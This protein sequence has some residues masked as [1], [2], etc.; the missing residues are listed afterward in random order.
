MG[1]TTRSITIPSQVNPTAVLGPV[2]E[3]LRQ[4]E[5]GYPDLT[6]VVRGNRIAIKSHSA[7]SEA[8]ALDAESFFSELVAAAASG[9]PFDA[10]TVRRLMEERGRSQDDFAAQRAGDG[11]AGNADA[12][13]GSEFAAP[14]RMKKRVNKAV[15]AV[16]AAQKSAAAPIAPTGAARIARLGTTLRQEQ[17]SRVSAESIMDESQGRMPRVITFALGVPVRPKTP[18]QIDYV[19]TIDRNVITFGIG[20]AGTGKTYLAVAKAVQAFE[21]KQVRRIILTRPAVEAGRTSAFCQAL[22]A[23][24]STPTCV[25]S[26]MRSPTCWA[27]NN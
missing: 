16:R 7:D 8:N 11:N 26:T 24:K 27:P 9:S 17:R 20:P 19:N 4:V 13:S 1:T 10:D 12:G 23:R 22:S 2:D 21:S 14:V 25:R 5:N 15:K 6:I 3:V 18:G